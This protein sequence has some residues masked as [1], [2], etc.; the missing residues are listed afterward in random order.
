MPTRPASASAPRRGL[1]FVLAVAVNLMFI[2]VLFFSI[3]WQNR[4]PEPLVA[5]LYAP[6]TKTAPVRPAPEPKPEPPPPPP[7]VPEPAP[8]PPPVPAAA[9]PDTNAAEI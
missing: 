2:A 5:E 7:P 3:R 9:P 6:P 4:P 8:P 1:A